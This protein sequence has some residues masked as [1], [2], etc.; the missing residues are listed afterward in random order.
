[1]YSIDSSWGAAGDHELRALTKEY[2]NALQGWMHPLHQACQV[3]DYSEAA[4]WCHKIR[5]SAG[6]YGFGELTTAAGAIEDS[7]RSGDYGR[8]PPLVRNFEAV[9]DQ[10][11]LVSSMIPTS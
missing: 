6:M 11:V 5:G 1:M 8:V 7:I 2:V 10:I 4:R 3:G 9:V